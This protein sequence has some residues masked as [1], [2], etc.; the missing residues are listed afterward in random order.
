MTLP[1]GFRGW[2]RIRPRDHSTNVLDDSASTVEK[3]VWISRFGG[4]AVWYPLSKRLGELPV[5]G[6]CSLSICNNITY[7]IVAK[8]LHNRFPSLLTG[9][10]SHEQNSIKNWLLM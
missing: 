8:S 4:E 9:R 7:S 5:V 6:I 3:T 2:A 10:C 1:L